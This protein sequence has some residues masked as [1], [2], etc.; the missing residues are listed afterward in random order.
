MRAVAGRPTADCS[1][2]STKESRGGKPHIALHTVLHTAHYTLHLHTVVRTAHCTLYY[3]LY[4][5]LHCCTGAMCNSCTRPIFSSVVQ[6]A[7]SRAVVAHCVIVQ[8]M[9]HCTVL[10]NIRLLPRTCA[11]RGMRIQ[12]CPDWPEV[13]PADRCSAIQGKIQSTLYLLCIQS[14]QKLTANQSPSE[15]FP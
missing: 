9:R 2:L 12:D 15:G 5:T 11:C 7:C 13:R 4:C 10:H 6:G 3:T 1:A 14:K 8:R